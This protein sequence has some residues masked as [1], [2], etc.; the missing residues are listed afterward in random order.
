M[1]N[2]RDNLLQRWQ[3]FAWQSNHLTPPAYW[4]VGEVCYEFV[5]DPHVDGEEEKT[6]DPQPDKRIDA[7]ELEE[8]RWEQPEALANKP[9][10]NHDN[11][12]SD[13][14][15]ELWDDK[16]QQTEVP[17]EVLG[18]TDFVECHEYECLQKAAEWQIIAISEC[19]QQQE[20][21]L[22]N[23]DKQTKKERPMFLRCEIE[24]EEI[25]GEIVTDVS[26]C[27]VVE[28]RLLK[29]L[30][31]IEHVTNG[32]QCCKCDNSNGNKRHSGVIQANIVLNPP[33]Q[34]EWQPLFLLAVMTAQHQVDR[35]C[36]RNRINL[37]VN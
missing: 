9:E 6:R 16:G 29:K 12:I 13:G 32:C 28:V 33:M 1:K 31:A 30:V 14:E 7:F 3:V 18:R 25:W 10:C 26:S 36:I 23:K 17:E 24:H 34:L 27:H 15:T 5:G 11:C 4:F 21:H 22:G 20:R 19:N 35:Q 2:Y 37:H 8:E